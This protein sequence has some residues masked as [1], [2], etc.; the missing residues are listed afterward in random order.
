MSVCQKAFGQKWSLNQFKFSFKL[1]SFLNAVKMHQMDAI[2]D[3]ATLQLGMFFVGGHCFLFNISYQE[4]N[5]FLTLKI[6]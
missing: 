1:N 2:C 6:G 5:N 4:N 3:K